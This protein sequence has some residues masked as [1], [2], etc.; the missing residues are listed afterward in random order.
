MPSLASAG[1]LNPTRNTVV[2]WTCT[3]HIS[4][5]DFE[6]DIW[7]LTIK[8]YS[9]RPLSDW[10]LKEESMMQSNYS[11]HSNAMIA[12]VDKWIYKKT[13]FTP[14]NFAL[15]FQLAY[16]LIKMQVFN[17]NRKFLTVK[18]NVSKF[19]KQFH[20]TIQRVWKTLT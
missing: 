15:L 5:Q 6:P 19:Q 10:N 17:T 16:F 13:Q 7:L 18:T 11:L 2:H 8:Y 14:V 4:C 12:A 1:R 9:C 3:F 20:H